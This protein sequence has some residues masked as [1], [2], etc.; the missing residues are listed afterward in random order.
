MESPQHYMQEIHSIKCDRR[1]ILLKF[2][3]LTHFQSR[4]LIAS[5][6][7]NCSYFENLVSCVSHW[8]FLFLITALKKLPLE[9]NCY[10]YYLL[11]ASSLF[12]SWKVFYYS[13]RQN[14]LSIFLLIKLCWC[15]LWFFLQ[16]VKPIDHHS[17]KHIQRVW[18]LIFPY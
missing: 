12:Y 15:W 4:I 16:Y 13:V 17:S 11:R 7:K 2:I 10:F 8:C 14:Y 5:R 6:L 3:K 1:M 9:M 18:C